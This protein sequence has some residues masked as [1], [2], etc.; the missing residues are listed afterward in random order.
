MIEWLLEVVRGVVLGTVQGLTEF[1]PVSSSGHLILIPKIFGWEDQGLAFDTVLHGGTFV[2]LAWYFR[3]SLKTYGIRAFQSGERG[4][5]SR[6]FLLQCLAASLP[7]LVL[8][9]LLGDWLD[10]HV[11]NVPLISFNLAFWGLILLYAD[12]R[13]QKKNHP[14]ESEEEM[15]RLSWKQAL[16]VGFAQP[17]AFLPGTSRSGVTITAGLLSGLSRSSAARFSFLLS[18]VS[19]GAAGS[20]GMLKLVKQGTGAQGNIALLA[21]FIAASLSGWL[22]IRFLMTYVAKHSYDL[23]AYYRLALALLLLVLL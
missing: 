9:F 11:R 19:T 6:R 8:G 10:Q 23:F 14:S 20:Y 13:S 7:A 5:S 22:A 16:A 1:L 17:L 2:A 15:E 3:R 4:V 21:G 18:L 12:R